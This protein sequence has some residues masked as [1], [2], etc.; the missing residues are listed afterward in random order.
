MIHKVRKPILLSDCEFVIHLPDKPATDVLAYYDR[1]RGYIQHEDGLINSRLT[2]SLSIHGFL[3]A[4]FGLLAG[5]IADIYSDPNKVSLPTAQHVIS[6]LLVLHFIVSGI[7][8]VVA[9]FSRQAILSA[10]NALEHLNVIAHSSPGL[11][12]PTSTISQSALTPGLP[13]VVLQEKSEIEEGTRLLICSKNKKGKI[14]EVVTVTKTETD[15]TTT[16]TQHHEAPVRITI[17][18]S[19]TLLFPRIIRG[20]ADEKSTGGAPSYYLNLP[21]VLMVVWM[22]IAAA[23]LVFLIWSLADPAH[24]FYVSKP[25]IPLR[26]L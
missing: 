7:G 10:H 14:E 3:F 26:F 8:V 2:W 23:S 1:M 21:R 18:G 24:T 15:F 11:R 4:M 25:T 12:V 6:A 13:Q 9:S 19:R 20:G 17:L 5:K 22:V 16:C